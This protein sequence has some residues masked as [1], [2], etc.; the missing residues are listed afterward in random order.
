MN[1]KIRV[2]TINFNPST[3]ELE[4]ITGN[5]TQYIFDMDFVRPPTKDPNIMLN[6]FRI[7]IQGSLSL[8]HMVDAFVDEYEDE[9]GIDTINSVS[10]LYNSTNNFYTPIGSASTYSTPNKL[11]LNFNGIDGAISTIDTSQSNHSIS[12]LGNAQL[13]IDDKKFGS[14]SLLLSTNGDYLSIPDSQDWDIFENTVDDWTMDVFVKIPAIIPNDNHYVLTQELDGNNRWLLDI[15]PY[16]QFYFIVNGVQQL[17]L[18]SS[19]L[20][21]NTWYHIAVVKKGNTY[22]LY[23]NGTQVAYGTTNSTVTFSAPLIVGRRGPFDEGYLRGR[24]DD[25]RIVKSNVFNANPNVGLTDTIIAP[26]SELSPDLSP[27]V[28]D[29]TLISQ[30]QTADSVPSEARVILFEEDV[31]VV[32]LN[33]DLKAYVSRDG[34]TTFTQ[35]TL[36][37]EAMYDAPARVL[38]GL[39][40]ISEQPSGTSMVYKI[41]THNTKNL[42]IHGTSMTWL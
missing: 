3:N 32:T 11:I 40:D 22:G 14:A 24:L 6:A 33:T 25:M 12:F 31:G 20:S 41:T 37:E 23:V 30:S 21:N 27:N 15:S 9:S 19:P 17:N 13:D 18:T 38:S 35:V 1:K 5:K 42:K 7:A 28:T 34:G 29:M 36:E 16:A 10:Q 2:T 8:L 39:A 26:R 4:I